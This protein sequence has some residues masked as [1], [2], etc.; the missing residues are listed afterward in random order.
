MTTFEINDTTRI[1]CE[2]V[3]TRTAFKH[4]AKLY[5]NR[6]L[7]DETKICY[8]NRTWESYEFESVLSQLIDVTG[9]LKGEEKAEFLE[10]RGRLE[11]EKVDQ[12]FG[13]ISSIMKIGEVL[14]ETRKD[15]NDWKTR[16]LKA[17]LGNSGLIMPEDWEQLPE[18]E[19]EKRLNN[20]IKA[21]A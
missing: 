5:V 14:S 19:K 16:M 12:Q 13:A 2:H 10:N 3:N 17:G 7:Q 15:K 18:E 4:V 20:I 9:I 11:K 6:E 21:F 8:Q 1:V